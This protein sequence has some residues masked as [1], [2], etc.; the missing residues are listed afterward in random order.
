MSQ[1]TR[2]KV[3]ARSDPTAVQQLNVAEANFSDMHEFAELKDDAEA[4]FLKV[5]CHNEIGNASVINLT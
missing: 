5:S 4:L 3:R 1:G 2:K